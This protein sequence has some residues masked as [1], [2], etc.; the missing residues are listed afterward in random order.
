MQASLYGDGTR[1]VFVE[2]HERVFVWGA[3]PCEAQGAGVLA[4]VQRVLEHAHRSQ[5]QAKV[6]HSA[7]HRRA[8]VRFERVA[9][10]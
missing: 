8:N 6:P 3:D 9:T 10:G 4:Q 7:D 5:K 2:H 1:R